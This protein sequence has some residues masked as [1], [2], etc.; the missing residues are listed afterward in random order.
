[1]VSDDVI[2]EQV[3][4][5]YDGAGNVIQIVTRQRY[6]NAPDNQTGPLNDPGTTPKARVT[7]LALY[8]DALGRTVAT[9]DYGT[10][11]GAAFT[12]SATIPARSDTVL[13]TTVEYDSA[14]NVLQTTDPKGIVTRYEYDD[15]GRKVTVIE[16]DGG[17]DRTTR[18]TYTPDGLQATLVAENADTGNQT[19][20]YTYGTT[21]SDSDLATST[22]L[23]TVAYPDSTG[24]GDTVTFSYNRQGERTTAT[25]QRGCVHTYDR[26][27]LGRL[28]QDRV[29][30]LG[31]GVD[32]AVRRLSAT[33]DVRGLPS[34]LTSHDHATV[35]SGS[36]VNQVQFAYNGFAQL[37][38][39]Y[40]SHSGAVNTG[41]SPN[42]QLAY[43]NGS[44]NTIRPTSLVY[45]DGR[46]LTYD[47]GTT[48]GIDDACSRVAS[49]VDDDGG[50]THLADYSFL[51]LGATVVVDFTEPDV[52]YT[53]VD[54]SGTNDPDTGDIYSGLGRFGRVKDCRWYDYG[55]SADTARL[56]YGYDRASNRLWR[57]DT[58]AV[59]LSKNFDELYAYDGLHRLE[60]LQRGRL[61]GG[62][63]SISSKTFAQAWTLDATGNWQGFEEAAT[64][65]SLTLDQSRDSNTVNEI[66]GITNSVGSAWA[67]PAHDPA[68]NMT[69]IPQPADPTLSYTATFD[70]WNRLVKLV[71]D[72]TSD[73]V[74]ENQY[75]ARTFRTVRK[76]YT[77]GTLSE[78]RHCYYTPGWRCVEERLGS[79]PDSADPDRQFVWGNRYI[80]DL[81]CRDRDTDANGSLD[82]RL[83]ATQDAN[84]NVVALID[85]TGNVQERYAYSAYGMTNVLTAGFVTRAT[86]S[87]QWETTY[88]GYRSDATSGMLAVKFRFYHPALG[89]WVTRDPIGYGRSDTNLYSYCLSDPVAICDPLGLAPP[90]DSVGSALSDSLLEFF[91]ILNSTAG[92]VT[93]GLNAFNNTPGRYQLW[94]PPNAKGNTAIFGIMDYGANAGRGTPLLRFDS[95]H[96]KL[97]PFSSS[98]ID[99]PPGYGY[100]HININ[101]R[102]TGRPDPH[103]PVTAPST[104]LTPDQLIRLN[105]A[106]RNVGRYLPVVAVGSDCIRLGQAAATDYQTG[107]YQNTAEAAGGIV[108]G[109]AVA[110]EGASAGAGTLG[111]I[112][113]G[114]GGP[115][116]AGVGTIAGG[117]L[118]GTGGAFAGDW[119]GSGIA[120]EL[121]GA[122]R[123]RGGS[124]ESTVIPTAGGI[125]WASGGAIGQPCL[126]TP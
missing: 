60:D 76:D 50:S 22:L 32:G 100:W 27:L 101:E 10:N 48:D 92:D 74:Q 8:P 120:A 103:I 118:G 87:Y 104:F 69:T 62:H 23:R 14:G 28:T 84:W 122:S 38:R 43:A 68:G 107:G 117:I 15:L 98:F 97:P 102:L 2:L 33:F 71:D 52:K 83:Y 57:E 67:T 121:S 90:A 44:A 125:N 34:L 30:T 19:T 54:L 35:G 63:T 4:Y 31:T 124:G 89:M 58:V 56:K 113:G 53:L 109:W 49:L 5:T 123:S 12:R 55:G 51:G 64:G 61:N 65:G 26:D 20:T 59:S 99:V 126:W 1:M 91:P 72:D 25:D 39:D 18:A 115:L 70:A 116:G 9:A 114:L 111:Y 11:G 17:T 85:T 86:S 16:D 73:T 79:S 119:I 105:R 82:E 45:P 93:K 110:F 78:E 3:E 6:H 29:T 88:C 80:D 13:V 66:T 42:V 24:G 112:G 7:Y 106:L 46:T 75:D 81:V 41:S 95:P 96:P 94:I 37:T 36:V 47:Y 77:G 40:Q 21:L 108:G